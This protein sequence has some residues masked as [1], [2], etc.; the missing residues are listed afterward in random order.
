MLGELTASILTTLALATATSSAAQPE[1]YGTVFALMDK[2]EWCP[3]GS[4]Y[5]D[6]RTGSYQL[7][8]LQGR[9]ACSK[10]ETQSPVEQGT[11]GKKVLRPLRAAY[12]KARQAG[13]RRDSCELV[14]SNGGPEVLALTAPAFSAVTPADEGCW[15]GEATALHNELFKVFGGQTQRWK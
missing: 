1:P 8:R 11:I 10:P 12:F 14:V 15:S 6:I 9:H 2:N 13:L 7:Y 5:L 3:G 4:V